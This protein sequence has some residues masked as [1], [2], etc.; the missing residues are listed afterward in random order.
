MK[1]VRGI[2]PTNQTN[3]VEGP[4]TWRLFHR[5]VAK[6]AQV[7]SICLNVFIEFRRTILINRNKFHK[8]WSPPTEIQLPHLLS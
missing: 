3:I 5:K 1:E 2:D 8:S 7:C 6:S 4:L